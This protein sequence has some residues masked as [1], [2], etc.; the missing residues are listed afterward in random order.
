MSS[1]SLSVTRATAHR[2]IPVVVSDRPIRYRT[3]GPG[4]YRTYRI[5]LPK[6]DS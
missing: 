5:R 3:I 6:Q 2:V 1:F 4:R